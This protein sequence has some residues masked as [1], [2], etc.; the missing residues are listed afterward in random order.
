MPANLERRNKTWHFRAVIGGKLIRRTTGFTDLARARRRAA[1]LE[2][3]VRAGRLGW[4]KPDVPTFGVWAEKFLAAYYP[5]KYTEKW[6]LSRA[7]ERWSPRPLNLITPSEVQE[8][9]RAREAE[10]A[11]RASMERE[12]LILKRLFRAAIADKTIEDNP[13][14]DVRGFRSAA[15][16]RILSRD[17]EV[18]IRKCLPPV[19]DRYLTVALGT[20]LRAGEQR[21]ARPMDLRHD[22]TW[23]RVRPESNKTRK[24]R[25]VPLTPAVI[26]ALTEQAASREGDETTPYWPIGNSA[27]Y[28]CLTRVCRELKLPA[29]SPHDLRRTFGT[30]CA[31]A[32]VYMK[33][34]Q[35]IMGHV[36]IST[37]AKYYMA[38][39]QKSLRDA[40]LE[41]K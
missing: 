2:N 39:E 22:G 6:A 26:T 30:R 20:G 13:C 23:L 36:D 41:I 28:Q 4:L 34:L 10:K 11:S 14:A 1:E 25:E 18:Q 38:L 7:I 27:A 31:E 24:G 17:H 40:L 19:W 5:D 16:T 8:Y 9:F 21:M 29:L 3:D 12:R 15:R 37:T 33:H 35:L 32:K